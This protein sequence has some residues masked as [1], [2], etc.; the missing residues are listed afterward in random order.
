M[1]TTILMAGLLVYMVGEAISNDPQCENK[2]PE[3]DEIPPSKTAK[4]YL[5]NFSYVCVLLGQT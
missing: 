1:I 3:D 5:L 2:D 4:W